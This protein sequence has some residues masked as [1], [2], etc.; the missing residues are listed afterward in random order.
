VI[1]SKSFYRRLEQ[2]F[3]GAGRVRQHDR[4]AVRIAPAL[5]E[6]LGGP[7]AV[8]AVHVYERR[9]DGFAAPKRFGESRPDLGAEL[10]RRFA[11]NE[12]DR[13]R[14]LPWVADLPEGRVGLVAVG[15]HDGPLLALFGPPPGALESAPSRSEFLSAINS[16]LYAMRQHLERRELEDLFEQAR[17]IQMS[18]L[19]AS[20]H[21]FDGYDI[22]SLST[23]AQSVGGDLYDYLPVAPG[24]L[25]LAL[26][27]ASGH[28]L[29]AAL[30][31]RDVAVGLR[32][33]VERDLKITSMIAKLNAVI[34]RSGLSSR[35]ISLFFGE[36]ESNGN[37][38]YIN[39]GHPPAL[40]QDERGIRELSVGGMVLGPDPEASYKMGYV[41]VD[42]GATLVLYSDGV[43]ERGTA[44]GSEPFGFAR[45]KKWLRDWRKGPAEDAV[46]D[47]FQRLAQHEP[48]KPFDDDVTVMLVRRQP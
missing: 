2:V 47:L 6:V 12:D 44:W 32:M 4:F 28:G 14:E 11:S 43:I 41:H 19:P 26:A 29:P 46:K 34:H 27:D 5:L 22:Y 45:L 7:L 9:K 48:G 40:L 13:V 21:A 18:L 33:G 31:A 3:E 16:L 38:S 35:F 23:P 37:F 10:A 42:R 24:T 39:A 17:A 20:A 30:Q 36:L 25:G 1:Q 15:N 8:S